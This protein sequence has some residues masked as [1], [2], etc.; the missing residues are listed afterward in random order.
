MKVEQVMS[1]QPVT[2]HEDTPVRTALRDL[3]R[4]AVTMLP[5]VDERGRIVGVVAE[6]DLLGLAGGS[7]TVTDAMRRTTVL[8]HPGTDLVEALS[9]LRRTGVKSLPVV[10]DADQVVGVVSRSDVVRTAARDDALLQQEIVDTLCRARLR[11]WRVQVHDGVVD[12]TGEQGES[13]ERAGRL[14]GDALGVRAVR[15]S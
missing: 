13:P 12:L 4:H 1:R 5:V 9:V 7:A 2:V 14:A 8:V 6:G 10:D 15:I 11:G 3:A